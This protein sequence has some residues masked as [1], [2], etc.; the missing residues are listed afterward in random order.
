[1][2]VGLVSSVLALTVIA[3]YQLTAD[4]KSHGEELDRSPVT[5]LRLKRALI[6]GAGY[7]GRTLARELEATGRWSVVGFV[8]D[9]EQQVVADDCQILGQR[10]Q[11]VAL[12]SQYHVDE[13]F[14]AY[15]PTWQQQLAEELTCQC[16]NVR[17]SAVPSPYEAALRIAQDQSVGDIALMHLAGGFSPRHE[18]TKRTFDIVSAA[19][20]LILLA[21]LL[22]FVAVLVRLTSAGPALFSQERV[23]RYGKTFKI[24]KVRT[25]V[26]DAEAK[27]G[28]VL[29]SGKNDARLTGVGK[30]LRSCRLDEIP[31]LWNVLRGDMSIVGPRPERPTF[32]KTFESRTPTYARRHQVRPGITG[33]AQVRGTYHTDARDKLRFDLIYVAHQSIWLDLRILFWTIKVVL[34]PGSK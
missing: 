24:Y 30:F 26:V 17:V 15:A 28:P 7:V 16:P 14:V 13:V 21:P 32:V 11:T 29:A 4:R 31:Q 9:L 3:K 20:G 33:L 12:A 34:C 27:T 19:I 18:F 22:A 5:T 6:V 23:G 2:G 1:M 8:D 25:M 10:D